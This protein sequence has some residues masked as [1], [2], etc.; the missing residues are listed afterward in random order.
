[1]S[2]VVTLGE[3]LVALVAEGG[4]P[5][6][7][8]SRFTRHVAGAEA[9]L[10]VGLARLGHGVVFVGRLGGDGFGTAALRRLRGEG[11]DVRHLAVEP[12]G[13]TGLLVRE[14]RGT[15]PS[16][17]WYQRDGSAA[18][19][20]GPAD[21]DGAAECFAGARWLHL[22]GITPALSPS[23]RAAAERA[24]EVAA[25]AGVA[26]ALDVNLRA[27]LW[28]AEEARPTLRSLA[29]RSSVTFTGLDEGCRLTGATTA[30]GVAAAF[31][32]AGAGSVVVKEG[33]AGA[34]HHSPAGAVTHRP[35]RPVAPVVDTVGAGDA[36]A[37]GYLSG[38]LDGLD[39]GGALDRAQV[40]GAFAVTSLGDL[41][42]LATRVEVERV[43]SGGDDAVR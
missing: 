29:A 4:G 28:S 38:L 10:A 41:D 21:V 9:N 43:L 33:P 18:S 36:F 3:C 23:C 37:A 25:A 39:P 42:G 31:L 11:V 16:E 40:C 35:A 20:L 19:R 34:S 24:V 30:A 22:T 14:R 27:K 17:V 15:G 13:R 8:A 32:E 2:D 6:A 1:M 5:L 7:E 26:V 12:D